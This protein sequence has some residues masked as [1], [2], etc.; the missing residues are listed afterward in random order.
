MRISET[1][2][3]ELKLDASRVLLAQGTL[4]PDLIESASKLAN[5]SGTA[6]TI[7]THHNDTAL[8][9]RL[10]DQGSIIEPL[11]DYHKD[12]V[13]ALGMDLG[14]PKHLVWRQPF[15]GPG[16]AIRILCARKPYLP[17][18]CDK[19]GKDISDVVTSINTS[20]KSTLLPC[21]SV[22]VQGDCR[23]YRS[24]VGLSCSSTNPNWSE[25][26]KIAR[27][28]PKK[29]HS[30]NRIVYVFGSELKESV[31][32]TITPTVLS[33]EC[34]NQLRAADD[35]VNQTLIKYDLIRKMSQVPVILFPCDFGVKGSRA[36]AVRTF[37]TNDFMTG[38]PATPGKEMPSDA[39]SEIVSRI[40]KEVPGVSRVCYDLTSKPPATTE[41]E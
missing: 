22:G 8:V 5:T 41:W 23:S 25:L 39:L 13:R 10:R 1:C 18:N 40:L 36:I 17:E 15:P 29:N 34:T 16:L 26:L 9:R 24:L 6:S 7:K 28:I 20:V 3:K 4:R 35:I 12:E 19:I 38:V 11:K 33:K 14:L 32:K 31:I 27:E 30:V 2:C 21:R 37:I